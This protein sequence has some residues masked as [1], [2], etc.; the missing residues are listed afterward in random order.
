MRLV[1]SVIT[2]M[3]NVKIARTRSAPTVLLSFEGDVRHPAFANTG[4]DRYTISLL[5]RRLSKDVF[6][7]EQSD[8][9]LP[10]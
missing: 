5:R 3:I 7:R 6:V 1:L 8:D 2:P 4:F 10:G 9:D